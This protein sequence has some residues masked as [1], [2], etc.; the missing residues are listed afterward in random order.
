MDEYNRRQEEITKR[1][2]ER[3]MLMRTSMGEK[4]TKQK[5]RESKLIE[6]KVRYEKEIEDFKTKLTGKLEKI[7]E[8]VYI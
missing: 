5:M 4:M 7:D 6:T 2:T 3:E 8:R 1:K